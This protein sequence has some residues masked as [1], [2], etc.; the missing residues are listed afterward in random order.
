MFWG[1]F[2][3][4]T[5]SSQTYTPELEIA[6]KKFQKRHGLLPDGVIGR[7][8][9]THL[10]KTKKQREIQILNNLERWRW[11]PKNLGKHYLLVNIPDF[12]L[13][14]LN[15]R[16]TIS[17]NK[18]I[19]GTKLRK[20]PLIS[21]T[22]Q[23]LVFN[24]TW[25]IPP[26]IK[27]EDVVPATKKNIQY[28][29]QKK[30]SVYNTKGELIEPHH[31]ESSK[32]LSYRYVQSPGIHNA[33]GLVKLMFKN[34]FSVYLHDTNNRNMFGQHS[35]ALSSGCVRVE[36]PMELAQYILRSEEHT[37]ELQSR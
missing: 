8:T 31:W 21:S 6:V 16:D 10:N 13:F 20:T 1:D 23:S 4:T 7:G 22:L 35:R 30:I 27:K 5:D 33:L 37:S 29:S 14:V 3:K 19:V 26:T 12:Q 11:Y 34:P 25:T 24:P 2:E 32:A 17:K 9:I 18:V 28:L 15:N 36:K